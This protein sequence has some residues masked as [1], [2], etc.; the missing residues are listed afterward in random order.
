MVKVETV[1]LVE[2]GEGEGDEVVLDRVNDQ[3]ELQSLHVAVESLALT[4][5]YHK[6]SDRVGE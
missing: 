5:Q 2:D 6:P 4:L 3:T 1:E